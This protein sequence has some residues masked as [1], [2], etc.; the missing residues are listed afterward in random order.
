MP[1]SEL[2]G[3]AGL[4]WQIVLRV[5]HCPF[6]RTYRDDCSLFFSCLPASGPTRGLSEQAVPFL[7]VEKQTRAA[8]AAQ[9]ETPERSSLGHL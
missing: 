1:I 3:G 5:V 8:Q 9:G 4:F 6:L 2:L 7:T